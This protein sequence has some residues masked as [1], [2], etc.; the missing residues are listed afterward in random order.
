MFNKVL[1]TLD[2]SRLAEGALIPAAWIARASGANELVLL[3]VSESGGER[4]MRRTENYLQL[5]AVPA[6]NAAIG[7]LDDSGLPTPKV[8]WESARSG[9]GKA[10]PSIIRF[11]E[12][13][14]ADL[15]VM[16][17]H[18][19]SGIDR[20]MMGSVA[21]KVLRGADIPVLTVPPIEAFPTQ[22]IEVKRLLLPLDGSELAERALTYVEQLAGAPGLEV[23]LL[24][25][26]P[27][28]DINPFAEGR[29]PSHLNGHHREEVNFYLSSILE[30]LAASCVNAT[31]KIRKGPPA[32][33]IIKEVQESGVG[34]V[35]MSSHGRTG[36]AE[37]AFGSIADQ[38][39]RISPAP[40][41]L[42]R[43]EVAAEA[44]EHLRGPLIYQCNH[45]SLRAFQGEFLAQMR[46]IRCNYL[47]RTCGNCVY[48]DGL[49]CVMR[50]AEAH[51][52]YP[53]NSCEDFEFR[54]ARA[55]LH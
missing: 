41:L 34:L 38:V 35:V 6:M 49:V 55:V 16:S 20:W 50:R 4:A 30:R 9:T 31:L 32:L 2:G 17:T 48:S 14:G 18:G 47:L 28:E 7:N 13:H 11:S 42:V 29:G 21:E 10:A 39:L 45:C 44:P 12:E 24:H 26:E 46:C 54:G 22:S 27:P 33:E 51:E 36:M 8:S 3:R 1:V 19:R 43:A 52:T 15:I 25:V 53:G 40:V 23:V 5:R 37:L